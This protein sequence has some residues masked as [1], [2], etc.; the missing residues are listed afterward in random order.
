MICPWSFF[1]EWGVT[2]KSVSEAVILESVNPQYDYRFFIELRVQY[3]KIASL[4]HDENMLCTKIVWNVK[5]KQFLYTTC[6]E[7]AIF[8]Y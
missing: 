2:G 1:L 5:T 3:K 7:L 8:L 4:E 6:S